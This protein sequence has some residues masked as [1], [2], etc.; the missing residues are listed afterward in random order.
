LLLQRRQASNQQLRIV[1]AAGAELR[2]FASS[3]GGA[4]LTI[5][6]CA[7][8]LLRAPAYSISRPSAFNI[9]ND[10]DITFNL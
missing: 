3:S 8:S 9:F 6:S 5:S 7:S 2:A 1:V 10:F 4:K